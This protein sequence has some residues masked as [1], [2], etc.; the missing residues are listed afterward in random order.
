MPRPAPA[1]T[2]AEKRERQLAAARTKRLAKAKE[3]SAKAEG[4]VLVAEETVRATMVERAE[5]TPAEWEAFL[6]AFKKEYERRHGPR[7]KKPLPK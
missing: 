6:P 3:R 4:R 2:K 7:T 1:R 5:L